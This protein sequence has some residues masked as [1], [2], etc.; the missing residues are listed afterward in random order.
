MVG[1]AGMGKTS[2]VAEHIRRANR[3]V[4]VGHC[5]PLANAS[6]ILP[7]TTAFASRDPRVRAAIGTALGNMPADLARMV[8]RLLPR[9]AQPVSD[10]AEVV[11]EHLFLAVGELLAEMA[12]SAPLNV[13]VEDL[14]WADAV[15]LDLLT[16]LMLARRDQGLTLI[17]TFRTDETPL[18][19]APRAWLDRMRMSPDVD[20]IH[21]RPLDRQS[22]DAQVA[23]LAPGTSTEQADQLFL[24]SEGNPFFTEQLVA[25]R[26]EPSGERHLPA[27]L[28][29]FLGARLARTSSEAAT[30]MTAVSLAGRPLSLT[31]L[32]R[33]SGLEPAACRAA[34]KELSASA[35]VTVTEELVHSRHALLAEAALA[36]WTTPSPELHA[37]LAVELEALDVSDL[38]PQIARHYRLAGLP[39]DELR[40]AMTAARR[41]WDLA[42]YDES[43]R[44]GLH[45]IGLLDEVPD[46]RRPGAELGDLFGRTLFA[47]A[48][49]GRHA[50]EV[51]LADVAWETFMDWPDSA[52]RG[53]VLTRVAR[54]DVAQDPR[55]LPKRA[56]HV[57]EDPTLPASPERTSL[58]E[59]VAVARARQ[60]DLAAATRELEQ[61]REMALR[62]GALEEQASALT[63][64]VVMRRASGDLE[65]CDA[66]LRQAAEIVERV[67]TP[68]ATVTFAVSL[69]DILLKQ[70]DLDRARLEALAALETAR[71]NGLA[72]S[73]GALI[74][75]ANAAEAAME[76]GRVD[77]AA[78]LIDP[79]FDRPL[80]ADDDKTLGIL[81]QLRTRLD[82]LRDQ[83][84][85]SRGRRY[86]GHDFDREEAEQEA[87]AALWANDADRAYRVATAGA[88]ALLRPEAALEHPLAGQLL[89]LAARACA[90]LADPS[91]PMHAPEAVDAL[92]HLA[93]VES[94]AARFLTDCGED[95]F[96]ARP[97]IGR[98]R[99][100]AAGW[101]A[102]R[103]RARGVDDV[104]VWR[105]VAQ[106]W[107]ELGYPHRAA[108]GWWRAARCALRDDVDRG[109]VAAALEAAHRL[110]NG[111]APMV[112]EVEQ[113]ADRLHLAGIVPSAD[114]LPV[115]QMHE[116]LTD[117][118]QRV[119]RLVA[120]GRTNGQIGQELYIS[121]K[122]ASVHVSNILR[123]LGVSNRGEAARWA[124]SAGLMREEAPAGEQGRAG[125]V[126]P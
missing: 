53:L 50:D 41:S 82:L 105:G 124:H 47:L 75:L 123:K 49:A 43:G 36:R 56:I 120:L 114:A 38:A 27:R 58:I 5:V 24:R 115:P 72:A 3:M 101:D 30:V 112:R 4:L 71:D 59:D 62:L 113:L 103:G 34:T 77:E 111:H 91:R 51:A 97:T 12:E 17:T 46:Q 109:P 80:R 110:A 13:V 65:A 107:E 31:Q 122:T 94:L 23:A 40:M 10:Q 2:L 87:E 117:Q 73:T 61:A 84:P 126:T 106:T 52:E 20:E 7:F 100:D 22:F 66:L 119:I 64:L 16:Y 89:T 74:L 121:R 104:P 37:R 9:Q 118:E 96:R 98:I 63:W 76:Q 90:D 93:E 21:L 102:E 79:A 60:G 68:R 108:Y 88:Q 39:V 14:H 6:S 125:A 11:Q 69:S 67:G 57:L 29:G 99:G 70:G 78:A 81:D 1:E 28:A 8:D 44:W 95:P 42:Q 15:T 55:T 45:A 35:L 25:S 54:L 86:I 83:V 18:G 116:S 32:A 48:Y 19:D 92:A 85:Q 33:I 26:A